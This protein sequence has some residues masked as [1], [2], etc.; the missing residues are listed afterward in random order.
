MA[1]STRRAFT[2]AAASAAFMAPGCANTPKLTPAEPA[3]G[4]RIRGLVADWVDVKKQAVG[5]SL[6]M[7]D[8]TGVHLYSH[9]VLGL[10][11]PRPVT[12]DT[13]F[14]IASLTKVFTGLMLC[15][16][17][18]R[19]EMKLADPV[20]LYLPAG[21]KLPTSNGREITLIDL[22]NH[23]TG[24]PQE[25]PDYDAIA[26]NIGSDP[27]APLYDFV[28]D[29]QLPDTFRQRWSYSN[30]NYAML[31]HALAYR[32]GKS[33]DD[34]LATRVTRPLGLR[35]TTSI[36]VAAGYRA[37]PHLDAV[38][39]A[40]DWNKPWAPSIQSTAEDLG[41]FLSAASGIKK[42][43]LAPAFAAMLQTTFPAPFLGGEQAIGWGID[44]T[45]G[46][47]RIFFAGRHP[48]FTSSMMYDPKTRLGVA[49]VANS[50]LMVEPLPREILRPGYQAI[51]AAA[52]AKAA[53]LA[54]DPVLDRF[55]GK[56]VLDQPFIDARMPV[57]SVFEFRR[58]TDG[59]F[60][61][62][63]PR[64]PRAP[65]KQTGPSTFVID[66][67]PVTFL[68]A[69]GPAPAASVTATIAGE[70]AEARRQ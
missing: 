66:G 59:S 58:L 5:V 46:D 30:I 33:Y 28:A 32:T 16:A 69:P 21:T 25:I 2:L 39:P 34:L 10:S 29:F 42:T 20:R 57:G 15:D 62:I 47:P 48:G 8:D 50:S 53:E 55:A 70:T 17:V 7:S 14:P 51:I 23:I 43:K 3:E 41:I 36:W 19:G 27:N 22:A 11:D 35:N 61:V 26:Q 49:A 31:G 6:S 45:F 64:Y 12:G 54:P 37:K 18:L 4:A 1:S 9:G 68:F 38:T 56:Y 65:L 63:M 40:P 52:E 67:F 44:R 13:V 24:F 60:S